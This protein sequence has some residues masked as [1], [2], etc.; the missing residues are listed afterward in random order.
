MR[1]LLL[2]PLLLMLTACGP[3][4]KELFVTTTVEPTIIAKANTPKAVKLHDLHLDVVNEANLEEFMEEMRKV[5][6]EIVFI[7]I[8]IDDYENLSLNINELRR[9]ILQQKSVIIYYEKYLTVKPEE[10]KETP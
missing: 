1:M 5:Q 8:S 7:A 2:A 3:G 10:A 4:V 9:Y 6:G